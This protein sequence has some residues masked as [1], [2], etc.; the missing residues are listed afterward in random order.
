MAESMK[1]IEAMLKAQPS[2]TNGT[3]VDLQSANGTIKLSIVVSEEDLKKG[4]EAQKSKLA[5]PMNSRLQITGGVAAS[6][7]PAPPK[8]VPHPKGTVVNNDRGETV[9][10]TLPGGH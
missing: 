5:A 4:I 6:G 9:K 1:L 8:T 10:V 2:S 7:R 3:K